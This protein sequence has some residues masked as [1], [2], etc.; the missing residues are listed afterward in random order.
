MVLSELQIITIRKQGDTM[1]GLLH[2]LMELVLLISAV[3]V[4]ETITTNDVPIRMHLT[5]SV[6]EYQHATD[7]LVALEIDVEEVI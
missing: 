2:E 6:Q 7:S 4:N 3:A 5:N 1:Y